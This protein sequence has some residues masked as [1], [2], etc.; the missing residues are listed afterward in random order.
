MA[1]WPVNDEFFFDKLK[2]YAWMKQQLFAGPEAAAGLL[3]LSDEGF[4][5]LY[6]RRELLHTMRARWADFSTEERK[7]LEARITAGPPRAGGQSE[8]DY[9]RWKAITAATILGWLERQGCAISDVARH[10]LPELRMAE[11]RWQPSWDAAADD[12]HEGRSGFV[13][14]EPDPSKIITAPLVNLISSARQHTTHSPFD[15]TRYEPFQGIV[16]KRPFRAVAALA[17]EARHGRFPVDFWN[18]ALVHWPENTSERLR[19]LLARRIVRLPTDVVAKLNYSISDWFKKNM[20]LLARSHMPDVLE[21]WDR[22]I[23]HLFAAG[24]AATE[25]GI[26]DLTIAGKTQHRSRRTYEHAINSPVG[27]M[28]EVLFDLLDG[29]KLKGKSGIPVTFQSR[30]TRLFEAPGEGSDH[31]VSEATIRLRWLYY[32]DPNWVREQIIPLFQ[33]DNARAEPSWNGYLHDNQMPVPALF[34]LL[35]PQFLMVFQHISRW[36][37]DDGP[38]DRLNEFLVIACRWSQKDARYISYGETRLALQRANDES[39]AHTVWFLG[40]IVRDQRAWK[41]FGKPFIKKAWPLEARF[42]TAR[43]SHHLALMAR[44]SGKHF[45]DVVWTILPLLV[46]VE[47]FDLLLI[48]RMNNDTSEG[49]PHLAAKF[50]EPMLALIDRL[51]PKEPHAALYDLASV[52]NMI[53][54]A[55]PKLRQ[56]ARWRRLDH[57]VNQ[58]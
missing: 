31:A 6:H 27:R 48:H 43:T 30:L 39:R 38:T 52:L 17:Y 36:R 11:P 53:A 21:L 42:Q 50:P 5:E 22:I 37:W 18:T 8:D 56:D 24:V 51:V 44:D 14:K 35:K 29:L 41:S 54:D 13:K 49:E 4:W 12:S 26:G 19:W 20:L 7:Q 2:I 55:D 16:D 33:L 58:A 3:S 28:A 57:L 23:D 10:M 46:P 45:S 40:T 9:A 47:H 34:E 1:R 25:S 15:F 32:L